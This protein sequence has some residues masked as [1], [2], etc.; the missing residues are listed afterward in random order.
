[1]PLVLRIHF[2]TWVSRSQ[3]VTA[4]NYLLFL[5]VFGNHSGHLARKTWF[6]YSPC[7]SSSVAM[8]RTPFFSEPA[9]QQKTMTPAWLPSKVIMVWM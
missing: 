7:F 8:S 6:L 2:G 4:L 3:R 5:M 9:F 1:M